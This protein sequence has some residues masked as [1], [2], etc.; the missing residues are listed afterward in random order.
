MDPMGILVSYRNRKG[1]H[2]RNHPQDLRF[3][4]RIGGGLMRDLMLEK[5]S[6]LV[7]CCQ[8]LGLRAVPF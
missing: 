8:G 4:G 6:E 7:F 3:Q 2:P 1:N 5:F